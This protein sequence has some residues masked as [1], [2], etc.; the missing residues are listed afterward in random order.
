MHIYLA[1]LGKQVLEK[2]LGPIIEFEN[3]IF[4]AMPSNEIGELLRLTR[5][6]LDL[7]RQ[8]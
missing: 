2:P 8:N 3:S 6:Y 7:Y 5:K 4:E 1:D